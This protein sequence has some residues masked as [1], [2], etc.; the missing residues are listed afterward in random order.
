MARFEIDE[1][2][3]DAKVR[4]ARDTA[5]GCVVVLEQ[6]L[7]SERTRKIQAIPASPA[8]AP[9]YR[10]RLGNRVQIIHP[11][12]LEFTQPVDEFAVVQAIGSMLDGLAWL[13]DHGLTH[14]AIDEIALTAG[15]TGGRLSLAGALSQ[16]AHA[17][18]E[19]DVYA[20]SALAFRL[21]VGEAVGPDAQSDVRLAESASVPVADAIRAGLDPVASR[22]PSAASLASKVR[23]EYLPPLPETIIRR[24][25]FVRLRAALEVWVAAAERVTS[26]ASQTIRPYTTRFT[27]GI[28][29]AF[30]MILVVGGL[31]AAEQSGLGAM[32]AA[33]SFGDAPTAPDALV[34]R[35][36]R[37]APSST[38]ST[39]AV[40][41]PGDV[42]AVSDAVNAQTTAVLSS[43]AVVAAGIPAPTTAPTTT[44]PT[45]TA[46]TTTASPPPTTAAPRP[47]TAI[48]PIVATPPTTAPTTIAAPTTTRVATTTRVTTTRAPTT[49][50]VTTTTTTRKPGKGKD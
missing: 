14:G 34:A 23:G 18:P 10:V 11:A 6:G 5:S 13:H 28:A 38:V 37:A 3:V 16:R 7:R 47:T 31:A 42:I 45:T 26:W 50:R 24:T 4:R 30:A 39:N 25:P 33:S 1:T 44:A 15:P 21:F 35:V 49:T 27:A 48:A 19:D 17:T 9:F 46:P 8:I 2:D 40:S 20:V 36:E 12:P 22:R 32:A 43:A 41:L 29:A